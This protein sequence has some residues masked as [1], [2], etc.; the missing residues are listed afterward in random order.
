MDIISIILIGIFIIF[1]FTGI[2]IKFNMVNGCV[3]SSLVNIINNTYV[4][5]TVG[6]YVT[7]SVS[8]T[9]DQGDYK[10]ATFEG[11]VFN[12]SEFGQN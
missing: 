10:N 4:G 9:Y 6:Q 12:P 8:S 3:D 1:I 7:S 2:A 11:N 5:N